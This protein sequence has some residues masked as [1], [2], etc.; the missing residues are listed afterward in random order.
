MTCRICNCTDCRRSAEIERELVD[1]HASSD[2]AGPIFARLVESRILDL[3]NE[4]ARLLTCSDLL[5][6]KWTQA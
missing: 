1:L 3:E 6:R 2:R 5:Q 4:S